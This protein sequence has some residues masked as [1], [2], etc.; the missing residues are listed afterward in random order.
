MTIK[1]TQSSGRSEKKGPSNW[2]TVGTS[3]SVGYK[4]YQRVNLFGEI[5]NNPLSTGDW[6]LL[7]EREAG[8]GKVLHKAGP[9]VAL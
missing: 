6:Q 7:S 3:D 4:Y 5:P 2:V 9:S 8:W 1:R